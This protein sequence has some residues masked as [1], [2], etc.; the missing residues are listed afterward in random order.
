MTEQRTDRTGARYVIARSVAT[1]QSQP[2]DERVAFETIWTRNARQRCW[3]HR[4]KVTERAGF[5]PAVRIN[6]TRPFQDRSLG[7]SD[8]SP[9][10]PSAPLGG[11]ILRQPPQKTSPWRKIHPANA[12]SFKD[13]IPGTMASG[14]KRFLTPGTDRNPRKPGSGCKNSSLSYK[15]VNPGGLRTD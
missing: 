6:P 2:H 10:V 14:I 7:H 12:K 15:I 9:T 13:T 4:L 8:T 3:M 11:L 1:K 5:E